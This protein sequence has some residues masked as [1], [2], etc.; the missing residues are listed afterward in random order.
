MKEMDVFVFSNDTNGFMTG[1]GCRA[2]TTAHY[3]GVLGPR[4]GTC[5]WAGM[6]ERFARW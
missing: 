5:S 3:D 1:S 2:D 6:L 4:C